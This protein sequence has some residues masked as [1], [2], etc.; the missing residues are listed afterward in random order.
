GC[1]A[2]LDWARTVR[3]SA[4]C[5]WAGFSATAAAWSETE[6]RSPATLPDTPKIHAHVSGSGLG[7]KRTVVLDVQD[8]PEISERGEF[9][10]K[11]VVTSKRTSGSLRDGAG[12]LRLHLGHNGEDSVSWPVDL[13]DGVI[14]ERRIFGRPPEI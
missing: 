7:Q 8:G 14:D 10:V 1:R 5:F 4:H 9:R 6:G 2:V 3:G 12:L 11:L 13:R